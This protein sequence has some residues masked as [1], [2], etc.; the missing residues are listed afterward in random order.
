MEKYL[1]IDPK[2]IAAIEFLMAI[3]VLHISRDA[4]LIG[5]IIAYPTAGYL[6]LG[7]YLNTQ[8]RVKVLA[9]QED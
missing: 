7:A 8:S 2:L 9:V 5:K 1:D 3:G 4:K 6:L